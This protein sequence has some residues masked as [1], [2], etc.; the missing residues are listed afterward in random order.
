[1]LGE[2]A[3]P[4]VRESIKQIVT[5]DESV[6]R[7]EAPITLH[8]GPTDILLALNIEFKDDLSSDQIEEA[9]RRIEAAIRESHAEVQRIFIEARSIMVES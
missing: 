8:L 6:T 5:G 9:I 7:M 1:M 4:E 3:Y 2:S